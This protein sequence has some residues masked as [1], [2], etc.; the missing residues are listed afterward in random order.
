MRNDLLK[1]DRNGIR[2]YVREDR[3]AVTAAQNF[4]SAFGSGKRVIYEH[5]DHLLSGRNGSGGSRRIYLHQSDA[6]CCAPEKIYRICDLLF[7]CRS[8]FRGNVFL[9]GINDMPEIV[10]E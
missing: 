8:N 4:L 9:S 2:K 6:L 5:G 1:I 7:H 10:E 3:Y